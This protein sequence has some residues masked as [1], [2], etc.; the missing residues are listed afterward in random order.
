[1]KLVDVVVLMKSSVFSLIRHSLIAVTKGTATT[2]W[3]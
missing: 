1:M 2:N 3:M